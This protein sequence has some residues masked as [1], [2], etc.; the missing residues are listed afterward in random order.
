M[1]QKSTCSY[2]GHEWFRLS[3]QVCVACEKCPDCGEKTS[4]S[5]RKCKNCLQSKE[6]E[7][8]VLQKTD[9]ND[10]LII[11]DPIKNGKQ[12]LIKLFSQNEIEIATGKE[13]GMREAPSEFNIEEFF[14]QFKHVDELELYEIVGHV[15][16]ELQNAEDVALNR[17]MTIAA[18]LLLDKKECLVDKRDKIDII[19]KFVSG[20]NFLGSVEILNK[21]G[22]STKLINSLRLVFSI[23]KQ[24]FIDIKQ[25][26][27]G[28]GYWSAVISP[29]AFLL[30]SFYY[31]PPNTILFGVLGRLLF[32]AAVISGSY[33]G[34]Q[35]R[36]KK[37]EDIKEFRSLEDARIYLVE[38][39]ISSIDSKYELS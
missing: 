33:K 22:L 5:D 9:S 1:F 31:F 21:M 7:D 34:L 4:S 35:M 38:R 11:L 17:I 24:D 19:E 32:C 25:L 10:S 28:S 8:G 15:L 23:N 36:D 26:T 14:D 3:N 2:C 13:G 12:E 29:I 30:I 16:S 39:A 18:F 6:L 27:G 20:S 37:Y